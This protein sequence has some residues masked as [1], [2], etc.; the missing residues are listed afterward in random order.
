MGGLAALLS[1]LAAAAGYQLVVRRARP[2]QRFRGPAPLILFAIQFLLVNALSLMLFVLGVPLADSPFGFLVSAL[3][4]LGGYVGVV[5]LFGVRSG[6][7]TWREMF[8]SAPLSADRVAFDVAIGGATMFGVAI[9]AGV[10]GGLLA[11]LLGT[12]APAVIPVP[13]G[14]AD[15]LAVALGA[16]LIVPVGEELLFRGYALTAWWRDLGPRA[17]LL[18]ATIFFALVHIVT[19]SAATFAEGVKQATLV[20][21]VIGPVGLALGWLFIRRGL[22]AA[23]AGHAAFNLFAILMLVLSQ[24]VSPP[25]AA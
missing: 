20:L 12:E 16:S 21:A 6:A 10:L 5:W 15:V 25:L 9:V 22:V 1:G 8:G 2:A 4:L 13:T 24:L 14:A 17:A 11:Q 23:I 18:R 19:L 7:L 3:V